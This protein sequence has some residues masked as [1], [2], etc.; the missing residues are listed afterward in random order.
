MK[1]ISV[2]Q[3]TSFIQ[4]TVKKEYGVD[5]NPSKVKGLAFA[6]LKESGLL[7]EQDKYKTYDHVGEIRDVINDSFPECVEWDDV[8]QFTGNL[9]YAMRLATKRPIIDINKLIEKYQKSDKL[10]RSL[11][12]N[13]LVFLIESV[14]SNMS[15]TWK[16]IENTQKKG[17]SNIVNKI[18][19]WLLE[20]NKN[21]KQ[22]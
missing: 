2:D 9:Y 1:E 15:N 12:V 20:R 8:E 13:D 10:D 3:F 5:V 11:V 19:K 22:N 4:E 17:A 7:S 21:E 16:Y 18:L 6:T 14:K